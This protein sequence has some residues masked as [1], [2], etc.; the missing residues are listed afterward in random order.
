M[1]HAYQRLSSWAEADLAPSRTI[2]LR[3]SHAFRRT[4]Y[5]HLYILYIHIYNLYLYLYICMI[6]IYITIN[7]SAQTKTP[8]RKLPKPWEVKAKTRGI[9]RPRPMR[10][11]CSNKRTWFG[12]AHE[13]TGSSERRHHKTIDTYIYIY[14]YIL[15]FLYKKYT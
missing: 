14:I 11:G 6:Y 15:N 9:K 1:N 12:C 4:L 2:G 10:V 3:L 13:R 5:C 8:K 7:E